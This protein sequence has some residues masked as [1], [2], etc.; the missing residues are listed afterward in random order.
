[1]TL[2]LAVTPPAVMDGPH[3]PAPARALA[4]AGTD[5]SGGALG[6]PLHAY[7]LGE[8]RSTDI[9]L[10]CAPGT[11]HLLC[12][13]A[14]RVAAVFVVGLS[15]DAVARLGMRAASLAPT[16]AAA[17]VLPAPV[18]DPPSLRD[19]LR[20]L[21]P[22]TRV[23]VHATPGQLP[24]LLLGVAPCAAGGQ[25]S[26]ICLDAA[27][28]DPAWESAALALSA[29]ALT[30]CALTLAD[31]AWRP[32]PVSLPHHDAIVA[33]PTA[34]V[35]RAPASPPPAEVVEAEARYR[36]APHDPAIALA[37]VDCLRRHALR[38]RAREVALACF[39]TGGWE[40]RATAEPLGVALMEFGAAAQAIDCFR[41]LL[42]TTPNDPSVTARLGGALCQV[43]RAEEAWPLLDPLLRRKKATTNLLLAASMVRRAMGDL[44]GSLHWTGL[45]ARQAPAEWRGD[46]E[47]AF[48]LMLRG[49]YDRG[50]KA[51]EARP[52][53]P[54]PNAAR[55]WRGGPL[56]GT[57]F[58]QG[59]QGI[60]D[61]LQFVRYLPAL[62]AAGAHRVLVESAPETVTLLAA[63][64]IEAV[65]RGLHPRA[66]WYV[67]LLSI[68][69]ALRTG[70]A[71]GGELV[72]YLRAPEPSPPLP[73][74]PAPPGVRRLGVV[75]AGNPLFPATATRDFDPACLPALA[76]IP[77]VEWVVLQHGA[78]AAHAPPSMRRPPLP[79]SWAG[80]AQWLAQL[81]GLVSIDSRHAD[82]RWLRHR[83][84]SPWYPT[85]KLF[86]QTT[87]GDW[88]GVLSKIAEQ[89]GCLTNENLPSTPH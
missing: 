75:W 53:P 38:E 78:A 48:T 62:R 25:L 85:A 14:S 89:L 35:G 4:P 17:P 47:R 10:D 61:L 66:D 87:A 22:D 71:L 42:A 80:T 70:A 83:T 11:G 40:P 50:W 3:R 76:E 58:V 29:L 20:G 5:A 23:V 44:D 43:G 88:R 74:P 27:P 2:P 18:T 16:G 8:L 68:P 52:A 33:L 39:A 24:E 84:D 81:D 28:D 9:L 32:R 41:T 77:G 73:L 37:L 36:G 7:L 49:D 54:P 15:H 45:L 72:P 12:A 51:Y 31:D 79:A 30:P 69:H 63:N 1:M 67:P 60:G 82:W 19:F 21:P 34:Q 86:R 6:N 13:A 64:G 56:S 59:E 57:L 26:A 46:F 55:R 65:P